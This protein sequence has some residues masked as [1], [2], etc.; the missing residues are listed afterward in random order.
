MKTAK[1]NARY[2][3]NKCMNE[4]QDYGLIRYEPS[5]NFYSASI[6]YLNGIKVY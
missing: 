5:V 1:I 3:Y 2:T 6:V 4:L